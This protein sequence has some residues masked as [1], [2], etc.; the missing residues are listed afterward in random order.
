MDFLNKELKQQ[1]LNKEP[2]FKEA[3]KSETAW[4]APEDLFEEKKD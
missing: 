1:E 3:E 2:L 4:K